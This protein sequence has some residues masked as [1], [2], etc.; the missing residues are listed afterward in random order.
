[1]RHKEVTLN[2]PLSLSS[3]G[4]YFHK[5]DYDIG[6]TGNQ[7]KY[8]DRQLYLFQRNIEIMQILAEVYEK[9]W[10][11]SGDFPAV[12]KSE[13]DQRVIANI[14]ICHEVRLTSL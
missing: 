7:S 13:L 5:I 4:S 8:M 6:S 1:M 2:V 9:A 3:T 10:P 14:L 11:P 12:D